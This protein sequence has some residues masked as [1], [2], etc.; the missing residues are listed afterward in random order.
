[1]R[2]VILIGNPFLNRLIASFRSTRSLINSSKGGSDIRLLNQKVTLVTDGVTK[3]VGD[4]VDIISMIYQFEIGNLH[5]GD[6]FLSLI[7]STCHQNR[8]YNIRHQQINSFLI[9]LRSSWIQLQ[10]DLSSIWLYH[11]MKAI[12]LFN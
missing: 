6:R 7:S 8:C 2:S 9:H 11:S 1:M 12:S 5:I 4:K 3:Y 10:R